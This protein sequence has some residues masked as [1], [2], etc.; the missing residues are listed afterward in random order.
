MIKYVF[1]VLFNAADRKIRGI[2]IT[3][4]WGEEL[5]ENSFS[6]GLL[7]ETFSKLLVGRAKTLEVRQYVPL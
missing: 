3:W 7:V 2:G 6:N 5:K 4:G 1:Q